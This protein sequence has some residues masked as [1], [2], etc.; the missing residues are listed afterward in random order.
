MMDS[1]RKRRRHTQPRLN[2]SDQRKGDGGQCV[3]EVARM[4]ILPKHRSE[5]NTAKQSSFLYAL[6]DNRKINTGLPRA[7]PNRTL[8]PLSML[9]ISKSPLRFLVHRIHSTLPFIPR[10]QRQCLFLFCAIFYLLA[11]PKPRCG[12]ERG[13]LA[14]PNHAF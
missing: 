2:G 4:R 5:K 1:S 8:S 12:T 7:P 13:G 9:I 14:R 11:C 10:C 3:I 6:P